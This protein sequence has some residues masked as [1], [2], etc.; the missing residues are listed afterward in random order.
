VSKRSNKARRPR[1]IAPARP[2]PVGANAAAPTARDLP[3]I[4]TRMLEWAEDR[5]RYG[6]TEWLEKISAAIAAAKEGEDAGALFGADT[7]ATW[8]RVLRGGELFYVAEALSAL[9]RHA[10]ETLT[11]YDLH[12]EDVPAESGV[13][14]YADPLRDTGAAD[15][16]G[17]PI[18]L[19]TWGPQGNSIVI[20][21]WSPTAYRDTTPG[22]PIGFLIPGFAK[23][24]HEA[25]HKLPP[26]MLPPHLMPLHG[27]LYQ[28]SVA[29]PFGGPVDVDYITDRKVSEHEC[30][31]EGC[32]TCTYA[33]LTRDTARLQKLIVATWLLMGQ[34]ITLTTSLA[35]KPLGTGKRNRRT[36]L[37]E[38]TVRYV[39]L[40]AVKR[41]PAA[42]AGEEK[43][44]G[45][46]Y[47][48]SWV[49]R[50]HWRRQ[51]YPSRG[52]HRPLWIAP[53]LAGPDDAPLIGGDRVNV[54]RR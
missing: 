10:A 53:H 6:A 13:M 46:V 54:L 39:E 48:H 44:S 38:D 31:G 52:E 16:E 36:E 14:F 21:F 18:N 37:L 49:V 27:Y 43:D 45:R 15:P 5:S 40:R 51:W 19:I 9:T 8:A 33:K 22:R 11:G 26:H 23:A 4:R 3:K 25:R 2:S 29:I 47:R 30:T 12:P 28:R 42:Q 20:D 1:R 50:G 24:M 17:A 32:Q 34:P 7:A 41:P 35:P